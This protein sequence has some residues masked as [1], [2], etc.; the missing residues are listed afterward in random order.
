MKRILKITLLLALVSG[1]I[2]AQKIVFIAGPDSHGKGEHEH[3]GGSTLLVKSIQEGLPGVNAVLLQSGW[4]KDSAVLN[5]AD[6]IVIYADG[7]GD[8]LLIPHLAEMDRLTKKGIGLVMLHFSLEVPAGEVGNHFK[9]WIGGYFEINW[10]VNPVWEAAFSTFP[11]HPIANGVKPFSITDEW[12]YHMRFADGMKNITPILQALPPESTLKG[13][14]GTHSNN[15]AVR[16]AVL[17]KKELQPVAW[18]LERPDGGRGFGFSGGHMHKNWSN[19]NFRKIVLNAIAWTAKAKIPEEGI[20]SATPT[21]AA[22]NA[23]TKKLD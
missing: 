20:P 22:L 16:E 18:A 23:L 10:S 21:E 15:P 5:D 12:Y 13:K 7:G 14:D 11:D 19:D 1:H 6:A 9:D 3:Q 17:T 8:H 2:F 4:P